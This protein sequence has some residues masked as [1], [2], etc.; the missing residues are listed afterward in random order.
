VAGTAEIAFL[1][2]VSLF[3]D[4]PEDDLASLYRHLTPRRYRRG[5]VLIREGDSG[6]EMFFIRAGQIVVSKNVK[7]R[8][9]QVLAHMGPGQF[10]G[11]MSLFD[12]GPRSATIQAETDVELY[13]ID[14]A[15]LDRFI[16]QSPSAAAAFLL[17]L[18]QVFIKRVRESGELVAEVTRWG[19]EAT[20]LDVDA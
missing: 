9:D 11:E 14:A 10:F 3:Q 12:R 4:I 15:S 19:L 17:Q 18:V 8:V 5:E 20:G 7:G 1:R 6:T 2:Q 13:S 16:E